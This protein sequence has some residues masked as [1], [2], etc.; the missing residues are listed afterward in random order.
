VDHDRGS[1]EDE[2]VD[3]QPTAGV[4]QPFEEGETLLMTRDQLR[5]LA[6][7]G[8]PRADD[9]DEDDGDADTELSPRLAG[10]SRDP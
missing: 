5:Q 4:P 1:P 10:P 8:T 9:D 6:E 7:R 2:D 3:D